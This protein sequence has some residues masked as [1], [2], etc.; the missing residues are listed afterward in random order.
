MCDMNFEEPSYKIDEVTAI[1]DS[2][3]FKVN[4]KTKYGCGGSLFGLMW[5]FIEIFYIYFG[6]YI[7]SMGAYYVLYSIEY[8]KIC[9]ILCTVETVLFSAFWLLFQFFIKQD[10]SLI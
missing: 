7:F 9:A 4:M 2:C 5:E 6:I 1:K 3:T 10:Y 8:Y